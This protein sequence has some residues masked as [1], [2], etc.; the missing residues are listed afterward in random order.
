LLRL[1]LLHFSFTAKLQVGEL[2]LFLENVRNV[3]K[4]GSTKSAFRLRAPTS[5]DSTTWAQAL[6]SAIAHASVI[7]LPTTNSFPAITENIFDKYK[8]T[9]V[10]RHN[11]QSQVHSAIS[12]KSGNESTASSAMQ[13][14]L[15]HAAT[16]NS[17]SPSIFKSDV[18]AQVGNGKSL[19]NDESRVSIFWLLVYA[20]ILFV[21]RPFQ[22]SKV[23]PQEHACA[24]LRCFDFRTM[25]FSFKNLMLLT[26]LFLLDVCGSPDITSTMLPP[27]LF[28]LLLNFIDIFDFRGNRLQAI[29]ASPLGSTSRLLRFLER[30][31]IECNRLHLNKMSTIHN[32]SFVTFHSGCGSRRTKSTI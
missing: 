30:L 8:Q 12:A 19:C 31:Y 24:L 28:D 23:S 7:R 32:C 25:F 14:Q 18:S 20:L 16:S 9:E 17:K 5:H 4:A 26:A 1:A 27:T 15:G 6:D 11:Q 2:V 3:V 10:Y 21:I 13:S 22:P 29:T